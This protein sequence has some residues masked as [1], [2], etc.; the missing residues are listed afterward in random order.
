MLGLLSPA[1]GIRRNFSGGRGGAIFIFVVNNFFAG[2]PTT[3]ITTEGR[4]AAALLS[5]ASKNNAPDAVEKTG[6]K[7]VL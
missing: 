1:M 5:T 3:Y 7:H 2:K 6:K 4:Y